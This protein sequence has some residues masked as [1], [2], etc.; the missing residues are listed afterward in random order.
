MSIPQKKKN[1]RKTLAKGSATVLLSTAFLSQGANAASTYT[2]TESPTLPY[3]SDASV[4]SPPNHT[5]S[6]TSQMVQLDSATCTHASGIVNGHFSVSPPVNAT[7]QVYNLTNTHNSHG[8]HS[9]HCS[10]SR[11]M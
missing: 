6:A 8:S 5:N 7:Y 3:P 4:Y 1:F 2:K 9:N 11:W 10:C